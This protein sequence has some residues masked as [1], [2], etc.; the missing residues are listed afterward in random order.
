MITADDFERLNASFEE[1]EGL[2]SIG[3]QLKSV[4]L[5]ALMSEDPNERGAFRIA[6][7]SKGNYIVRHCAEAFGG[8]GH[9]NAAGCKIYDSKENVKKAVLKQLVKE[10]NQK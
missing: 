1:T 8:G 7:R 2:T 9:N 4:K 5:L 6:L 10:L 3:M